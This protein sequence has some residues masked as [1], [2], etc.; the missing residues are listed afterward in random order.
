MGNAQF[1]LIAN[2]KGTVDAKSQSVL[3]S[4]G[5]GFSLVN[6]HLIRPHKANKQIEIG[7]QKAEI[8]DQSGKGD[9]GPLDF[10]GAQIDMVQLATLRQGKHGVLQNVHVNTPNAPG[11]PVKS[12][13]WFSGFVIKL[14]HLVRCDGEYE[15]VKL[16]QFERKDSRQMSGELDWG[17]WPVSYTPAN[18]NRS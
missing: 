11:S 15:E 10:G 7:R 16:G 3:E 13:N 17:Y 5:L 2:I 1:D 9:H 6:F 14:K 18:L 8:G 4:A 12:P